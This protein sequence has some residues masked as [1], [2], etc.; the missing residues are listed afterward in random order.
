[1][2]T[3]IDPWWRHQI[4]TFFALRALW[5]GNLRS[6]VDYPHKRQWRV[7]LMF[8]LIYAWTNGQANN[9]DAGDLRHHRAHYA[10]TVMSYRCAW[11]FFV[12]FFFFFC[13]SKDFLLRVTRDQHIVWKNV[14]W[15]QLNQRCLVQLEL[16]RQNSQ[17][18]CIIKQLTKSFSIW[19]A[20]SAR[21]TNDANNMTTD[22]AER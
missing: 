9:W 8:S 5:V 1:M 19:Y 6:P 21:E 3:S 13:N 15:I 4:E 2:E 14:C 7:V 22:T 10:V 17:N 20:A 11:C 16:T 18:E 12:C